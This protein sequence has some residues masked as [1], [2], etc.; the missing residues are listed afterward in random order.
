MAAPSTIDAPRNRWNPLLVLLFLA[1]IATPGL[2]L[3]LGID[4]AAL[5]ESEMRELAKFPA[6]SWQ[7]SEVA[8]WPAAFQRYF[9]DH[10]A[11]R[12][13]LLHWQS[14]LLWRVLRTSSSDTVIAGTHDWL[15][16]ADDGGIGDYVSAYPFT[17]PELEAWR[18][19]LERTRDWLNTQGVRYLVVIA[20][21]KYMIYPEFMPASLHRL[22]PDYRADQLLAY[23][24][25]KS[26]VEILDLRPALI[27]AKP[28]DLLYH[29]YD[30]HWND[31]GGLVGYQ[32]IADRLHAWWPSLRPLQRADFDESPSVPSGDK[33]T[34]LG[35][36]DE[37]KVAM[38]GLVPRRGWAHRVVEP[39]T[40]DPY[41][42]DGRVAT[43]V[44]ESMLPRAVMFRDSFA[45]RLMPYLSEHFS[46]I[47]YL[48]ENDFD[49]DVVRQEHPQIVIQ[50][51][52]ARHLLVYAPYPD[53]IPH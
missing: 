16:Y 9:E 48:W 30:T 23:M 21:D 53:S 29:R 42:E 46:R 32:Q 45:G 17:T 35:L 44:D 27:A 31:R 39:S 8:K 26:K 20:P 40:P 41:G 28:A 50:E 51:Y 12:N 49:P 18:L 19:T 52:V 38:P 6:W 22:R 13:Q 5:S 25:A 34:M 2:G 10:F 11:F 37:G 1:I 24:R 3:A 33:T 36:T 14:T 7:R 47:V 43:E 4:R 15:F